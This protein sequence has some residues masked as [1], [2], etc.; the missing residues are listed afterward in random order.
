M[1]E[2]IGQRKARLKMAEQDSKLLDYIY[3]PDGIR[4]HEWPTTETG[5]L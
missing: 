4:T 1:Y 3:V 5:P 2:G